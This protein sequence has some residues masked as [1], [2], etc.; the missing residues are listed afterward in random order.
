MKQLLIVLSE[1]ILR[2]LV[3][4]S[5][6][7]LLNFCMNPV[8]ASDYDQKFDLQVVDFH[9]PGY[10]SVVLWGV[11]YKL[12]FHYESFKFEELDG[13][14][15]QFPLNAEPINDEKGIRLRLSEDLE[16]VVIAGEIIQ[17]DTSRCYSLAAGTMSMANCGAQNYASQRNH[18]NGFIHYLNAQ[19]M[20]AELKSLYHEIVISQD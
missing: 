13:I 1:K 7:L 18:R 4:L 20:S 9:D 8:H 15:G 3:F 16:R 2:H 12:W 11:T 5:W 10:F 14:R 17:A 6:I 19:P